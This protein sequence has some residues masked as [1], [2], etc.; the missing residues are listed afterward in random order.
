MLRSVVEAEAVEVAAAA[1]VVVVAA[2]AAVVVLLTLAALRDGDNVAAR[3]GRDPSA[4]PRE[5]AQY[6]TNGTRNVSK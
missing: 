4:A 1:M 3:N 5:L 2:A 6:Q